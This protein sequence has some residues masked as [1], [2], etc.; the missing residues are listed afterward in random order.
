MQ[1]KLLLTRV[2]VVPQVSLNCSTIFSVRKLFQP[3]RRFSTE[4]N[5][6]T[7]L[8]KAVQ[9]GDTKTI[10]D[11]AKKKPRV[12]A[13]QTH[14]DNSALHEAARLGKVDIIDSLSKNFSSHFNVNH[15]CHC[16]LERTP[17]H[18]AVEGGHVAA[19]EKLISLGANPNITNEKKQTAMDCALT[20]LKENKNTENFEKIIEKLHQAGGKTNIF[21]A[22][23]PQKVILQLEAGRL[24]AEYQTVARDRV[25]IEQKKYLQEVRDRKEL[26]PGF[27]KKPI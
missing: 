19:V 16:Y 7:V 1:R 18:Y 25:V 8:I 2:K 23:E 5:A 12:I 15:K 20:K 4:S 10:E 26:P 3:I 9:T 22:L 6:L 14:N 13:E 21:P 27:S 11:M 24:I 17:L